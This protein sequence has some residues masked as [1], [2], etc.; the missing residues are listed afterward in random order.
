MLVH[1]GVSGLPVGAYCNEHYFAFT[2][3]EGNSVT[4]TTYNNSLQ[5][6]SQSVV[7]NDAISSLLTEQKKISIGAKASFDDGLLI[8]IATTGV[9]AVICAGAAMTGVGMPVAIACG[10]AL[11]DHICLFAEMTGWDK[12][13]YLS[14]AGKFASLLDCFRFRPNN[15]MTW[16]NNG[17]SCVTYLVDEIRTIMKKN[18]EL[19]KNEIYPLHHEIQYEPDI[20]DCIIITT[21]VTNITSTSA[22]VSG[23]VT[24]SQ[25]NGMNY[26]DIIKLGVEY[27]IEGTYYDGTYAEEISANS[28]TFSIPLNNLIPNTSYWARAYIKMGSVETVFGDYARF[29]TQLEEL[30][31][32]LWDIIDINDGNVYTVELQRSG[33]ANNSGNVR[34]TSNYFDWDSYTSTWKIENTKFVLDFTDIARFE[35]NTW[36]KNTLQFSGDI[37]NKHNIVGTAKWW[38]ED[39]GDKEGPIQFDFKMKYIGSKKSNVNTKQIVRK[40]PLFENK[41]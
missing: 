5:Q 13:G 29:D 20:A 3:Y 16:T 41:Q 8:K 1:Y 6:I 10:F 7:S 26:T 21:R 27:D 25:C 32:G 14:T 18:D 11:F 24:F 22:I 12:K 28:I 17:W 2:N 30:Y 23:E 31:L 34:W 38:Y 39:T 15:P 9:S 37:I 36:D 35:D 40:S 4:V 33:N 19:L